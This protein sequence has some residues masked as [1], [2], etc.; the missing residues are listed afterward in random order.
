MIITE[1]PFENLDPSR[2]FPDQ[3]KTNSWS[4][5][6]GEEKISFQNNRVYCAKSNKYLY[7]LKWIQ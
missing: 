4:F 2:Y 3:F 5:L 6:L 7:E 1:F